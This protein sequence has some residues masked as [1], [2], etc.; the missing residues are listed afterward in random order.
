MHRHVVTKV[1]PYTPDQLFELVGDVEAYPK[2]VPWITGMRTWN[3]RVDG[4]VSTVDAEAQVGFSFLREKFATRVRRDKDARSI[5]VSLLYGPFKR[6]SNGWRFMPEGDATRVE[7]VIEFA[8][9]SAL[10]DAMLAAN[11][12]RAAGKLI[13]CFEARA[14]QLHGA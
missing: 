8:F 10:L 9:K 14:Q 5:D 3:G 13:A 2:F 4:P 1:L 12:D 7:F 6:L 11:V